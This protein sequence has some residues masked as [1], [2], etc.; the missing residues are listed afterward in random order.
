MVGAINDFGES[1]FNNFYSSCFAVKD[2]SELF[3]RN[4]AKNYANLNAL[5]P[6]REGNGRTQREFTRELCLKCGY[7]FDLSFTTHSEMLTASKVALEQGDVSLLIDIFNK[8]IIPID[9]YKSKSEE[10]L[11]IL[12]SDD[13]FIEEDLSDYDYTD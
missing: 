10:Y 13:L 12:T 1:I 7:V 6:F 2:N 4:V 3:I 5:H 8:A 11:K 9:Q